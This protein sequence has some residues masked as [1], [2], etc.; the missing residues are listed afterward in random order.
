ML[1]EVVVICERTIEV[2]SSRVTESL[3]GSNCLET[4]QV[5]SDHRPQSSLDPL[6]DKKVIT[7]FVKTL[8]VQKLERTHTLL[9]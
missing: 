6:P 2:F 5:C 7:K 3:L 4:F 1:D 9:D 8:P